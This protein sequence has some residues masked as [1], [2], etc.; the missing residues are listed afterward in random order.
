MPHGG[1]V[2]FLL[3]AKL[4]VTKSEPP[5]Q[6]VPLGDVTPFTGINASP[7]DLAAN[8]GLDALPR[9]P[10]GGGGQ[11]EISYAGPF[12]F[13]LGSEAEQ[14][15][16]GFRETAGIVSP[17]GVYLAG[18]GFWYPQLDRGLVDVRARRDARPRA[19]T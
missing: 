10:A 4:V 6:Q 8:G 3:N 11:I 16:R 7:A 14:Y 1:D 15:Q 18:D 17:E 19:G 2:E 5:A 9:P 13:G 12:D